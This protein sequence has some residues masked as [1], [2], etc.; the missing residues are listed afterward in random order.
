MVTSIVFSPDGAFILSGSWDKSLK[1]WDGAS[2]ELLRTFVG[3]SDIVTSVAFSPDGR[4]VL[5]ASIDGI[6]RL[7]DAASAKLLR[8]FE[9]HSGFVNSVA[10]APN[11]KHLLSG[12]NDGSMKLWQLTDAQDASALVATFIGDR[13]NNWLSITQEGFYSASS[14]DTGEILSIVRGLEATTID[15]VHQS[16]FNPDL[17]REALGG[18][19]LGEVTRATDVLDLE[20]V[21]ESG[22]APTVTIASPSH[23][24]RSAA[25][26]VTV[27]VRVSDRGK[28]V[29][30]VE[31]RVNNITSAIIKP[32]DG[33]GTYEVSQ[34][35]ALDPGENT[36]EVVAYNAR[37]L[38]ASLPAQ[39]RVHLIGAADRVRPK[40][41][42]LAIGINKYVDH[43]WT[44]PGTGE[45]ILFRPLGLAV[46]DATS[47]AEDLRKAAQ[48]QYRDVNVTLISDEKAT[49]EGVELAINKLATETYP[50]DTFILF[51]AAHGISENGRFY[52]IPQDYQGGPNALA[53]NAIDQDRLQDWLANRIKAKR[54][55]ILLDTCESGA[56]VAGH[57]RSRTNSPA[58]E[59]AMGRLHEATGRPVLTAAALG[60][61]AWEGVIAHTGERHGVFTWAI[62]D[63]LRHGDTNND[64]LIDLSELVTH[65]QKRVAT[66]ELKGILGMTLSLAGRQSARFGS[67]GENFVLVRRL[68]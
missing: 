20:K 46:S 58:S 42:I 22:P 13:S 24:A 64:G 30:R 15:Q 62:L 41:H 18:D 29:G 51:A 44:P 35:V 23:G 6:I 67:R 32:S 9:G 19:V 68:Q 12:S 59:A 16:L 60:Q 66:A 56:L 49:Q 3:Q 45:R 34:Q 26:L 48:A 39:T 33:S 10:V 17:V 52:L 7:W 28:G 40:L 5:S 55:I 14:R 50:R 27:Q 65:V 11:G 1:L 21:L 37:N 57:M 2:G 38:L 31:F 36:I 25:D 4:R 8:D 54:A 47:V 43:G 61:E 53:R 63:A